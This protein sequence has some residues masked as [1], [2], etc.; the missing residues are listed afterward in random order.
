MKLKRFLSMF[1]LC[2]LLVGTFVM[3]ASAESAAS[4][5]DCYITVNADGDALVA[6]TVTLHMESPDES[7]TFPLPVNATGITMNGSPVRST[8]TKAAIEVDVGRA[9]GGL[10]GD[11]TARFDFSLPNVVAVTEE[12]YLLLTL[13]LLSGFS[14]PVHLLNFVVTLPG[15]IP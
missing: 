9:T 11:F 6:M 4:K 12:G 14:Y 13:P 8:K 2:C 10:V 15:T 3:P 5:V 1:L 7:L